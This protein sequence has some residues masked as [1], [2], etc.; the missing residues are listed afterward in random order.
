MFDM[1]EEQKNLFK[2]QGK[3]IYI[4]IRHHFRNNPI[5]SS[6]LLTDQVLIDSRS[7]TFWEN[8]VTEDD[9]L[10]ATQILEKLIKY[11]RNIN[12]NDIRKEFSKFGDKYLWIMENWFSSS[13]FSNNLQ[14]FNKRKDEIK[15][16]TLDEFIENNFPMAYN[17]FYVNMLKERR[18]SLQEIIK[19]LHPNIDISELLNLGANDD[20]TGPYTR[21][22]TE[23]LRL[24]KYPIYF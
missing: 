16:M 21:I 11:D 15:A 7:H 23:I 18:V 22:F 20:Y 10:V 5:R 2:Q 4:F 13:K 1:N 24:Y 6:I 14:I 3:K 17:R 12:E 9:A 8:V 19:T